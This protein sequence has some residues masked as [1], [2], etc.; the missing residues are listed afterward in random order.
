V[1]LIPAVLL[2]LGIGVVVLR[3]PRRRTG[4]ARVVSDLPQRLLAASV[5]ILAADRA[6]WGQ[7]MLAELD[8]IGARGERW[9]FM[10]G[11]VR[12]TL[13][14]PPRRG[15]PGRSIGTVVAVAAM[16]C[17]G[18]VGYGLV[19]YPQVITGARTWVYLA[20]FLGVL[21]GYSV[22]ANVIV[23]RLDRPALDA[24][25]IA[26]AGALL[27]A[28]VWLV[29][30]LTASFDGPGYIATLLLLALPLAS[31]SA[32][33]VGTW[34]GRRASTGRQAAVLWAIAA[35]MLV[36]LVWVSDTLLT[37]G[38]PYDPGMV[39]DFRTSGVHDLATYAV[40]DNLGSAMMLLL[41][42]PMLATSIGLAGS[43]IIARLLPRPATTG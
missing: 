17:A 3:R 28:A 35:G 19:R 4:A 26:L 34:R 24:V 13:L 14:L 41:L 6:D 8:H 42:V 38:R 15:A 27:I 2:L 23:R 10:L 33:A 37:A 30:A 16:A 9:R 5:D 1:L 43:A 39:R 31:L 40:S 20:L 36:F 22:T 32:G 29:V 25:R 18:L 7:A 12:A 21:A 11:C